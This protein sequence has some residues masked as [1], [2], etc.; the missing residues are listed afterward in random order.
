MPLRIDDLAIAMRLENHG[1]R[2]VIVHGRTGRGPYHDWGITS[3]QRQLE[4]V[5]DKPRR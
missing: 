1:D 5:Y 4:K 3:V 2:R